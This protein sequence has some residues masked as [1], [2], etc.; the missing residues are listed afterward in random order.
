LNFTDLPEK[1]NLFK[2]KFKFREMTRSMCPDFF[3][4][5]VGIA[6]LKE[7]NFDELPVPFII[8]PSIG[9]FSMGVYRV[10]NYDDWVQTIDS[11]YIEMDQVKGL[12]PDVVLDTSSFII[13]QYITGEEFA[14]DAYYTS[15]GEPV[16]VGIHK[17][18]FS[19]D[20]DVSDRVYTTSKEIIEN[21]LEEFTEFVRDI[22]KLAKVKNFPVHIELR[23]GN[24]GDLLP[25]EVNPMRFGGWCTTADS[26]YGAYGFNPYLYY[27]SQKIPDWN[28]I[29]KGKEDKIFSIVILDNSTGISV[30]KIKSFD[31]EKLISCFEK[32]LEFRKVDHKEYPLFG[33]LFTETRVD[34]FAELDKILHSDL[35]EFVLLEK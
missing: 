34:N 33:F 9:F 2:D 28:E 7:I 26:T 24:D 35:K 32:P 11:I 19:S 23:R 6:N 8:K 14:V 25:I 20:E 17:H 30:D 27:Y 10:T 4:K 29:L 15:T 3:Y 16:V 18:T 13:E 5:E 21:N 12:Y 31:S 1:I 22:G